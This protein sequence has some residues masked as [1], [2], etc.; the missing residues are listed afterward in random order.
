[1]KNLTY[2]LGFLL[3]FT[4]TLSCEDFIDNPPEDQISVNE[5]F[6]TA[7]DIENYVKKYYAT[8]PSHGSANLPISE[9]NSDNLILRTP[10]QVLNGTR[11]P[12]NGQWIGQWEDIRSINILFDNLDNVTDEFSSYQQFLG[13]AH[14]FRA[15]FYFN[16][17]TTY[18]DL[19]IYDTQLFPD[20]EKLLDPRSP[21]TD[22][23]DFILADLDK[24]IEYLGLRATTGNARLNKEAAL[25]FKL[26]VALFEGTWQKYHE[27]DV[28]GTPGANPSNYFQQA[29]SAGEELINGN[30]TKGIYNTGNPDTDY[31][32]LFGMDNMSNIDEVLFYRIASTAEQMGHELQFYTTRRTRDM[33][34]TWSLVSSYLGKDGNAYDYFGLAATTKGNDFLTTIANDVDPRLSATIWIPG[35]L[36]VASANQLFNKPFVDGGVEESAVTGFQLKKFSNPNSPAAGADFGGRSET[37]YI[38]FRYGEVLLN[39]AEAK[40]ELDGT[41]ATAQLNLL[42]ERVG[43]PIF[44][45]IP[46]VNYGANLVDYGYAIDDALYA[47]RNERRVELALEGQRI[48]D[49]KRW[50]AHALFKGKRPLGYPFLQS[51]FPNYNTGVDN[52]GLIDFFQSE[53]PNGYG[54]REN[55]DYL[56]SIPQDELIL[57]PNLTQNPGW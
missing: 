46:Q 48:D 4:I 27:G 44:T 51:E 17:L 42:R 15:W 30:Y 52:N 38:L 43:M 54:F 40:Y 2:I 56:S 55:Q 39:Y 28:F 19:P 34:L 12:S 41:I 16:L 49:Y 6:K 50:A 10:N 5:F 47:I 13:E 24:S 25:A 29:V 31:Y 32:S 21:R 36:R 45:V 14:F 57:N 8:F 11:A 9:D 33:S 7:N 20:D 26:R 53:L 37:G 22:V 35:D 23:A 1:M 3:V 18:G